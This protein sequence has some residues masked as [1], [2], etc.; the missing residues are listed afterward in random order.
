MMPELEREVIKRQIQ[1]YTKKWNK[2]GAVARR[3]IQR[4][5]DMLALRFEQIS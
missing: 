4:K 3:R 5:I 2:S 1:R